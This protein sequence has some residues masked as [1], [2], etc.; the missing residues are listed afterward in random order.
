[1]SRS[2]KGRRA[3]ELTRHEAAGWRLPG[4]AFWLAGAAAVISLVAGPI[5]APPASAQARTEGPVHVV[6]VEGP[7]DAINKAFLERQ[8]DIAAYQRAQLVL[9]QIDSPGSLGRRWEETAELSARIAESPVPV[10]VWIGPA[11]ARAER[12]AFWLYLSAHLRIV[13][14]HSRAGT[15]LPA[16]LGEDPERGDAAQRQFLQTR[17]PGLPE[18]SLERSL[19]AEELTSTGLADLVAPT[20]GDAIV[21]LDG[22][23][24]SVSA[25]ETGRRETVLHTAEVITPEASPPLRQ[26][27]VQVTFYKLG[28][29][30]RILHGATAPPVAYM[31]LLAAIV[32]FALEFYTAGIGVVALGGFVCLLV[33]GYGI[34]ASR[35]NAVSL[36]L[37]AASVPLLAADIHRGVRSSFSL[38]G[39]ACAALG[40]AIVTTVGTPEMR[41]P[42][43]VGILLF[44][45]Y[46]AAWRLGVVVM[47]RT[48]FW[49]PSIAREKLLGMEARVR[50]PL[51]PKGTVAIGNACFPAR[52]S[53]RHLQRGGRVVVVGTA[54]VY[55]LVKPAE[56]GVDL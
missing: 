29:L 10:A 22:V 35:P 34:G 3:R 8:L 2:G 52:T 48:R 37:L 21:A 46:V 11:P 5:S 51:R 40:L 44:V 43:L 32:L 17:F 12:G 4:A 7:I 23:A 42:L 28:F 20:L 24:V 9:L 56:N 41:L 33:G 47:A 14:P 16:L 15:A 54:G 45:L 13:S 25:P 38:A 50:D 1:M 36:A 31:L 26:P 39:G 30:Q 6:A 19:D 27:S 18:A 55:L 53:T 49:A